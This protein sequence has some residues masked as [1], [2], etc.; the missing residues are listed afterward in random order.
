[1]GWL[2]DVLNVV[3]Y[4][5]AGS[6]GLLAQFKGGKLQRPLRIGYSRRAG[7]A[8]KGSAGASEFTNSRLNLRKVEIAIY[9][10]LHPS[11][12]A[13]PAVGRPRADI[14]PSVAKRRRARDRQAD[15]RSQPS[16]RVQLV[17]GA[18]APQPMLEV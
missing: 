13:F 1:M 3:R 9:M 11:W 12:F 17:L 2:R 14:A 15:T 6:P 18:R 4:L 10:D 16:A 8:G 5:C 7:T